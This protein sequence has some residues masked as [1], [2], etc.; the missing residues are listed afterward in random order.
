MVGTTG[1]EPA[2][3]R[4]PSVRATRLRYVPTDKLTATGRKSE[5]RIGEGIST[6]KVSPPFEQRQESAQRI[7]QIEQHLA[8]QQLGLLLGVRS[9]RSAP[10]VFKI[11]RARFLAKVPAGAR[12]REPVVVEEPLD[13]E[14]H[15]DIFL[16]VEAKAAGA[17]QRLEHGEFGFPV[18][19]DER[20]QIR[21]AAHVSDTIEAFFGCGSCG[22]AV[23]W[24]RAFLPEGGRGYRNSVR[25]IPVEGRSTS[26]PRSPRARSQPRTER[27]NI[28]GRW[29]RHSSPTSENSFATAGGVAF[30]FAEALDEADRCADESEFGAKLV[31]QEALVA[32]VQ[33]RLLVG[34]KEERG[35]RDF[36]LCNVVNAHGASLRSGA[37]LQ[38]DF[39]LEPIVEG[40]RGDAAAARFPAL[41][42]QRKKFFG[43]LA[44]FR[45]K[46][47][48]RGV[49]QKLQFCANHF[50]VVK[51]QPAGIEIFRPVALTGSALGFTLGGGGITGRGVARRNNGEIPLID[52]D[53]HGAAGLFGIAG[54]LRVALR[55]ALRAV[56]DQESHIRALQAAAGHDHAEFFRDQRGLALAANAGSIHKTIPAA[57]ARDLRVDVVH[58]G[59]GDGGDDGTFFADH[60]VE[61]RGLTDVGA[62]DDGD[63]DDVGFVGGK[64]GRGK[65]RTYTGRGVSRRIKFG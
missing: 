14:D 62:A 1:F 52:D 60:A 53:D 34:E 25:R 30:A 16:A 8:A 22:G 15:V 42:D 58:G 49:A 27:P 45:G 31:F 5:G 7:A 20:F 12:N 55:H 6:S 28:T 56:D 50:F 44:G 40:R 3:S 10:R 38:V 48:D 59:A 47:N 23:A 2:T 37:A 9:G 35:R 13:A 57:V 36:R 39:F 63:F 54:D 17:F 11:C 18:A 43:A 61:Q 26:Q 33:R 51:H 4:T 29:S 21:Q 24:H 32:E 65:P 19:K 46:K 64:N 41:V